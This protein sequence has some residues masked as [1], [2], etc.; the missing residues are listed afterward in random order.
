M[1]KA[2]YR[3]P[4]TVVL[5]A[6]GIATVI[7]VAVVGWSKA[8]GDPDG[9][10]GGGEASCPAKLIF[11]GREYWGHGSPLRSPVPA[12]RLGV[13]TR[14]DCQSFRSGN[15]VVVSRLSGV[16]PALVVISS[17]GVWIADDFPDA[18]LP[19]EVRD[20]E[21]PVRCEG[22]GS[23]TI[24][25]KWISLVYVDPTTENTSLEPPYTATVDADAGPGL[26]LD[27]YLSVRVAVRVTSSTQGHDD[28]SLVVQ[29][30]QH[31]ERVDVLVHC[32]GNRFVA[33]RI[34]LA[35]GT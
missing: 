11:E 10:S 27:R 19:A 8:V 18:E 33:D 24:A 31:G 12:G 6:A 1:W 17:G 5:G 13:A 3:V 30:L 23:T 20:L 26:P 34:A 22:Q 21:R 32:D 25:G 9:E 28:H 16:D 2:S 29:A 35:P 15:G 4:K 14:P 7:A